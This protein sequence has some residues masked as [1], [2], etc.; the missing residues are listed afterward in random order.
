MNQQAYQIKTFKAFFEVK[1]SMKFVT[2]NLNTLLKNF[3]QL[4]YRSGAGC[5]LGRK[6]VE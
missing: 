2:E 5:K 3:K 6:E 1:I 4:K